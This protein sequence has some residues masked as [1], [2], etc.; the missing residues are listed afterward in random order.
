MPL[1]RV[2]RDNFYYNLPAFPSFNDFMN[3]HCQLG[4]S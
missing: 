2:K 1:T 3:K 4:I